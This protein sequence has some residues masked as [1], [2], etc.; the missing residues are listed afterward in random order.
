VV[1]LD[2]VQMPIRRRR[3]RPWRPFRLVTLALPC[4]LALVNVFGGIGLASQSRSE[5]A[6]CLKQRDLPA[7]TAYNLGRT[8]DGLPLTSVERSCFAPGPLAPHRLGE[9]ASV[10]WNSDAIYGTCTPEGSEGTCDPPLEIQ[11]YP[12]CDRNF[13]SYGGVVEPPAA[14][15]PHKSFSLSDSYKIPTAA[16]E[17][18]RFGARLEM[19]TGQTTVEISSYGTPDPPSLARLAAHALARLIVPKLWRVSAARLRDL[20]VDPHGCRRSMSK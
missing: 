9:P 12:E 3:C 7:F 11:S 18:G 2:H 13:S 17:Y 10:A 15:N 16:F 14:L 1:G 6:P 5:E 19:Y 8:F 20:A 4:A